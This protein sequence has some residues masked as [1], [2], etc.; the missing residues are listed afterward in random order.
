MHN[1]FVHF[2]PIP[3][4]AQSSTCYFPV[5]VSTYLSYSMLD[6]NIS[7]S[8]CILFEIHSFVFMVDGF[9]MQRFSNGGVFSVKLG[10]NGL[11]DRYF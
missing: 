10:H 7:L 9:H 5:D 1:C 2:F 11:S 6:N 8:I 4:P 3:F